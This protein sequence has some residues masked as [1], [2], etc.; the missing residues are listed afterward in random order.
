M[1]TKLIGSFPQVIPYNSSDNLTVGDG[2][3]VNKGLNGGI[4]NV[5]FYGTVLTKKRMEFNRARQA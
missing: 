3:S 5:V 2:D 1:D 4:C